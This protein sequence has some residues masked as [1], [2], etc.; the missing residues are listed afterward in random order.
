MIEEKFVRT[1]G[2]Y[3]QNHSVGRPPVSATN[4]F[5]TKFIKP[6]ELGVPDI[7]DA[8]LSELERFRNVM[9]RFLNGQGANIC[10]Q[11]NL[12]SALTKILGSMSVD[13]K[14]NVIVYTE[15]DFPSIGFVLTMAQQY[16]YE[17][18]CIPADSDFSSLGCWEA[19][20]RPD[21]AF[22]LATH[23]HSNTSRMIDADAVCRLARESGAISVVDVAQSAG[24]V[25]VDL[26]NWNADFLIGSCVKF[27]CGG[28]GAGYLWASDAMLA[29]AQPVDVGWFSHADPF[30]FDIHHFRHAE[31]ALRFWG[32]TPSVVPF[33]L[34]A[35]SIELLSSIGIETI[36]ARSLVLTERLMESVDPA[37]IVTPRTDCQ[38]GGTAV[39]NCGNRQ[40]QVIDR[41]ST[42]GVIFDARSTGIRLSPHVYTTDADIETA[43]AALRS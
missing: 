43:S 23:V 3:L 11:V 7:W 16:G 17:L 6:W 37:E 13:S 22:V 41:L 19:A 14:R 9:A 42:A 8:W 40:A 2:V 5:D 31:D 34:A 30:E 24:I 28:P 21:C 18:R 1:D 12:S 38:R 29:K 39:L 36:R 26:V 20:I 15:A 27:L 10:P 33:V 32:G 4:S 25:P 35:N